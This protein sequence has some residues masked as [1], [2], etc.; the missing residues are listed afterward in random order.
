MT[1]NAV[2]IIIGIVRTFKMRMQ[3]KMRHFIL[4][5]IHLA[6]IGVLIFIKYII[7]ACITGKT[8]GRHCHEKDSDLRI[9]I[10]LL[11]FL[12]LF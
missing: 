6:Q 4:I 10:C 12:S 2:L 9:K 3:H 7:T 11:S 1:H 5:K 8:P